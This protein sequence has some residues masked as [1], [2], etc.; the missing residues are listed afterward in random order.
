MYWGF[1][2]RKFYQI[3]SGFGE[4]TCSNSVLF[5]F[6]LE[7]G[8]VF[9]FFTSKREKHYAG[10]SFVGSRPQE[11]PCASL[12]FHALVAWICFSDWIFLTT[13][14]C[15]F[16]L[17]CFFT[18]WGV[19]L[20]PVLWKMLQSTVFVQGWY[21]NNSLLTIVGVEKLNLIDR[22]SLLKYVRRRESANR[23]LHL[24]DYVINRLKSRRLPSLF[25][26]KEF[27]LGRSDKVFASQWLDER[28]VVCG[29]KSN[30]VRFKCTRRTQKC[31]WRISCTLYSLLMR[32]YRK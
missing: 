4:L 13:C 7:I 16:H 17:R 25:Q 30:Q 14:A 32:I 26:E 8:S 1:F 27:C 28:K 24:Q 31:S 10:N 21:L 15:I 19:L 23:T 29:T 9:I 11:F 3:L 5:D 12:L 22:M 18:L 6:R 20:V 2:S